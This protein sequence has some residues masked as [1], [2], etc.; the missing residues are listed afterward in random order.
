LPLVKPAEFVVLG[1]DERQAAR[2]TKQGYGYE[3]RVMFEDGKGCD[4]PAGNAANFPALECLALPYYLYDFF[5][6]EDIEDDNIRQV[7]AWI[8]QQLRRSYEFEIVSEW[9]AELST[10]GEAELLKS[11]A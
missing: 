9:E 5:R 2:A 6:K 10:L 11:M 1:R 3:Q 7:S 8:V 4:I